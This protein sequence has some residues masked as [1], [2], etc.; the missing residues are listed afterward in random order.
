[1]VEEGVHPVDLIERIKDPGCLVW[2]DLVDPSEEQLA[3]FGREIGLGLTGIEDALAPLERPKVTRHS[4]HLFFITYATTLRSRPLDGDITHGRLHTRRVSG[5]VGDGYLVTV[6]DADFDMDAVVARWDDNADLLGSGPGALVHGLLDYVVD[7][8]FETI[9]ALDDQ[10][11]QLEDSLFSETTPPRLLVRQIYGVR[12]DLV[13]LRRVVLPMRD[14]VNALLRHRQERDG[15]LARWYDDL[16]DHVLR[17]A[18]WT[19]SLRDLVSTIFETNLSLQDTRLNVV[20]KK[21]SGWAAI[22]AV[23][24]AVTGWFGQNVP[25]PGFGHAFG[26]WLSVVLIVVLCLGL[27]ALFKRRDW[28]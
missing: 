4:D 11:E 10:L 14:V 2:A 18:E 26:L 15:A 19:D 17:A 3:A 5:F 23:P 27:Y 28:L 16:Y 13:E 1:M 22:V 21:L 25:Y 20:M 6:R 8:H 9:Q 12:R 7:G 24:T